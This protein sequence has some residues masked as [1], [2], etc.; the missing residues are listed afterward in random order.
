VG[1]TRVYF[2]RIRTRET[3]FGG[4]YY[5]DSDRK[6]PMVFVDRVPYVS[7]AC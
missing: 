5:T 2:Y 4:C 3:L 7:N 6:R 1:S